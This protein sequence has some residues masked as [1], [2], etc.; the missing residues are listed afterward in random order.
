MKVS[1]LIKF[2]FIFLFLFI[3]Q[4]A[5]AQCGT[6]TDPGTQTVNWNGWSFQFIRPCLTGPTT[7]G[8]NG[9]GIEI[10]NATY[11]GKL[12]FSKAHTPILNV[13]Y[14]DD[15]CGPI[16]IGRIRNPFLIALM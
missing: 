7:S 1:G 15:A 14:K 9:G 13:K 3:Y 4:F 2:T 12:V 11:N 16:E 10:R 8:G 5:Q 6:C